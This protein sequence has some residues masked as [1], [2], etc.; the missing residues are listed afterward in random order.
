MSCGMLHLVNTDRN[1]RTRYHKNSKNTSNHSTATFEHIKDFEVKF[2]QASLPEAVNTTVVENNLITTT[3]GRSRR[4]GRESTPLVSH[5][6]MEITSKRE[7]CVRV[8]LL[9]LS[10]HPHADTDKEPTTVNPP[11]FHPTPILVETCKA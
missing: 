2:F 4:F 10:Y 9:H 3:H 6:E 7:N 1:I 5:V 8:P 11:L